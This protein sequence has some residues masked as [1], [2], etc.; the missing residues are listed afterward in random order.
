MVHFLRRR[1]GVCATHYFDDYCVVEPT[2][3]GV[4][5]QQTLIL[6]HRLIGIPL[7]AEKHEPASPSFLFLGVLTDFGRFARQRIVMMKAKKGRA[8]AIAATLAAILVAGFIT[9]GQAASL[10]GKL[11]FLL[12]TAGWGARLGRS[13]LTA[14]AAVRRG[15]RRIPIPHH[16]RASIQ[17]LIAIVELLPPRIIDFRA[18][19]RAAARRSVVIWSDAM[20][21][22]GTKLGGLGF[23]VY[24]P[25]GH[26]MASTWGG[27][28]IY[29]SRFVG[30]SELGFLERDHSLIGQLE[31]IAA[32]AP[33]V[34]FPVET[35]QGWDV[36]HFIDNTSAL[37]GMVKGYSSR[38]DSLAIIRAFHVANLAVRANVWFNYVA[39]KA[40]VADLPS[41][42]AIAEMIGCI[43]SFSS[44]FSEKD[45]VAFVMP[46][47]SRDVD[48]IWSEV[49]A[50][51]P[52]YRPSVGSGR[53]ERSGGRRRQR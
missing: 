26:P 45:E 33:Y 13:M 7:S 15:D 41:R 49:M 24:F 1:C 21:E 11:Q 17:F 52:G 46:A 4:S 22:E 8:A 9:H 28:F 2:F 19:A 38:P 25:P 27:R 3:A 51:F 30:L 14:F 31:L 50:Q 48:A 44:G 10:R 5:G 29:S 18:M 20:W 36:L 6:L 23:V 34:S 12:C 53:H 32:A 42:G 40:N 16:L 35:F 37:Y 47:C 43:A 39:S